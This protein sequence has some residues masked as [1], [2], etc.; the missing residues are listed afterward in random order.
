MAIVIISAH[1]AGHADL[2]QCCPNRRAHEVGLIL[3]GPPE[4][5]L[6]FYN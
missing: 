6:I 4:C 2:T 3:N 1:F 5:S